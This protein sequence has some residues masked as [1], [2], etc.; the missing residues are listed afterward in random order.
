MVKG[1]VSSLQ[2]VGCAHVPSQGHIGIAG[3]HMNLFLIS[4]ASMPRIRVWPAFRQ[5]HGP[6]RPREISRDLQH[7]F[8]AELPTPRT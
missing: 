4:R 1:E 7:L 6:L 5:E 3:I 2:D 8:L